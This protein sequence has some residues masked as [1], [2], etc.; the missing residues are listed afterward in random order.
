MNKGA[1]IISGTL[2]LLFFAGMAI[3]VLR[4]YNV[5]M[6]NLFNSSA[7]MEQ[8]DTVRIC[9]DIK[10]GAK[11][12]NLLDIYIPAGIDKNAE[13]G[14]I[15]YLHGGSWTSGDKSSMADDCRNFAEKG[16]VTATMNYSFLN[17]SGEEKSDFTTMLTEIATALSTIKG[18]AA[19]QGVNITKAALSG[20]SAG[21]HLAM[22][23]TYSMADSSPLPVL[24]VQSKAGPAD[25]STF[26][27]DS[28][29]AKEVM[30]RMGGDTD[31][32]NEAQ[33]AGIMAMMQAV[34]PANHIRKGAAPAILAYGKKDTLVVWEN[35]VSLMNAF[36]AN[37]V[38]YTLVEYPNSDHGLD[39]DTDRSKI[40]EEKMVE[41]AR[42]HFG[43]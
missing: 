18:Y 4:A 7:A 8:A 42:K 1:Y 9:E 17:F 41:F 28:P 15:L 43:Y 40:T 39:K 3:F 26:S 11:E 19:A 21:A 25:F 38:E 36:I 32:L 13:H 20:Y 23:Y 31:A 35:V 27:L 33:R 12:R 6:N 29:D 24:F 2:V 16:Y 34:S 14:L 10:Y 30:G 22:L 5:P 37:G